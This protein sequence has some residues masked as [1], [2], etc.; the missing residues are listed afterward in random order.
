M[1]LLGGYFGGKFKNEKKME[2]GN[3]LRKAQKEQLPQLFCLFGTPLNLSL[4]LF[5]AYLARKFNG[6]CV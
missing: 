1:K 6:H 5:W 3:K 2:C 4:K